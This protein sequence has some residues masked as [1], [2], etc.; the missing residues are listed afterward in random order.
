M[1]TTE[2]RLADALRALLAHVIAADVHATP[3]GGKG[4]IAY[5]RTE[6]QQVADAHAALA[7]YDAQQAQPAAAGA[8][9]VLSPSM[10][11]GRYWADDPPVI[12]LENGEVM[13]VICC[14]SDS[15]AHMLNDR[16]TRI[17]QCVNAHDGLV[18]ALRTAREAAAYQESGEIEL[19]GIGEEW[20]TAAH[21]AL[22]AA[23]VQ[24]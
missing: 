12:G 15:R 3:A 10:P 13:A 21:D 2:Q 6:Y 14:A 18:S 9:R 19:P 23:G 11:A 16:A 4:A 20:M 5:G 17:V 24:S 7:A 1:T 22:A 8:W